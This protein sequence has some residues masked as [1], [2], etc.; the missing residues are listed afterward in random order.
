MTTILRTLSFV[1]LVLVLAAP[2][3]AQPMYGD[4]TAERRAND[5]GAARGAVAAEAQCASGVGRA[6][7]LLAFA[8][9]SGEGVRQDY[10]KGFEYATRACELGYS[11]GCS[12]V[13]LAYEGGEGV[14]RDLAL[15]REFSEKGCSGGDPMGC[16]NAGVFYRDGKGVPKDPKR[17]IEFFDRGCKLDGAYAC[18]NLGDAYEDGKLV[19]RDLPLA[20]ELLDISCDYGLY[21]ACDRAA[22]LARRE[23]FPRFP[24]RSSIPAGMTVVSAAPAEILALRKIMVRADSLEG[25]D[26]L[27][28]AIRKKL[29]LTEQPADAPVAED[30]LYVG[31]LRKN[32]L[33]VGEL[34]RVSGK[35]K[36][37]LLTERYTMGTGQELA[38]RFG[39]EIV[40]F[41]AEAGSRPAPL[42]L[43]MTRT[44]IP[45]PQKG[46]K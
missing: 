34:F 39:N 35:E 25:R 11:H 19:P 17:G 18:G 20:L 3:V 13:G 4:P 36:R 46:G 28:G 42:P 33:Y 2:A 26:I 15:A 32:G 38:R 6:C 30:V 45:A 16:N 31:F 14:R 24:N 22:S 43:R 1:S 29:P 7:D 23:N 9:R 12:V 41:Y 5:P 21:K 44:S 27:V 37:V 10:R 8:Y 40:R